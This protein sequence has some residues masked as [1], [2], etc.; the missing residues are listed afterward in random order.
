GFATYASYLWIEHTQGRKALDDR[1]RADYRDIQS[2]NYPPPGEPPA[3]DLFNPSV[4]LRG[5]LTLH[6]LRLRIGDDAFFRTLKTYVARYKYG[7]ANTANFIAVAKEVS[8]QDLDDLFNAWLYASEM[9]A[10]PQMG[11]G[12]SSP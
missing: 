4:Y 2:A 9:P 10:I 6:A 12:G 1:I 11:L 7:N 5:S 3:E 8:G